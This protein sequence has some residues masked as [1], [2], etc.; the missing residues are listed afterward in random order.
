MTLGTGSS[1]T[2]NVPLDATQERIFTG[3]TLPDPEQTTSRAWPRQHNRTDVVVRKGLATL[4]N[5]T[6]TPH[7]AMTADLLFIR[8]ILEK[9]EVRHMLVRGNDERPVIVVDIAHRRQLERALAR[10]C[11]DEPLYSKTSGHSRQPAVLVSDGVL[12][13]KRKARVFRLFRPRVTPQ[14]SLVYGASVG[15]ELQLWKWTEDTVVCPVENS[16]TRRELKVSEAKRTTVRRFDREWETLEGMFDPHATDVLLDIDMVFSWVDGNDPEFQRQRAQRMANYVAGEGDDAPARYRHIDEL[17]YA[18][19]S[20]HLFAPW[21][22]TIYIATDSPRPAWLADHPRVKTVRSEEFFADT[23]VLPIHNSHAVEAQ[24]HRIPGL[25]EFYLYSNDDMFFGRPIQPSMFFSPGGVTK[26][27]EATTRIGLGENDLAR[28]GHDNAAR[29]NRRLLRERF[30]RIITRHLEHTAVPFRKSLVARMEQEFAD[31]FARTAASRFR[32]ATDISVTNSFYHYYALM[33]GD[34]VIQ[35]TARV[36]YVDSTKRASLT[37]L[38]RLLE[39]RNFDFFCL[40]DSSDPELDADERAE[41][42]TRFL[43]DYFPIVAP[44]E[45]PGR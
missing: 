27:I 9:H 33:T 17:R 1:S 15:V 10:E 14:G 3:E 43:A 23:S 45:I 35:S 13:P 38:S 25:S 16:L 22:R 41:I 31:D 37:E 32:S 11:Q 8:S 2:H 24:I 20:V 44:W 18:L 19:R 28:S 6:L 5:T 4:V 21:V 29:V 36:R 12:S 7:E 30:G 42:V 34:A 39:R 40:N 26:F